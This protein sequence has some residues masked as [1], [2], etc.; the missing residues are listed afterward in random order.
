MGFTSLHSKFHLPVWFILP[1]AY[2][3][4]FLGAI[5][6]FLTRTP[7][8]IVN[9]HMKLNPFAVKMLIIHRYFNISAAE[10]DLKYV[11]VIT[12][13]QGWEQT[14]QWFR[15]NWLPDFLESKKIK[16]KEA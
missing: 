3:V 6:S 11:P 13:E 15:N 16:Q 7:P 9:F 14:K 2:V 12:F 5:F 1:L 4:V 10:K 8:H